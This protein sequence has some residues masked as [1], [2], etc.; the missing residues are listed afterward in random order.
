[1]GKNKINRSPVPRCHNHRVRP[2]YDGSPP[3]QKKTSALGGR[4]RPW[5]EAYFIGNDPLFSGTRS[6][7][8]T[9]PAK[10]IRFLDV[11][12]ARRANSLCI[13]QLISFPDT[14]GNPPPSA[15]NYEKI[16]PYTVH[17]VQCS[18]KEFNGAAK[19][20][21]TKVSQDTNKMGIFSAL[22]WTKTN[23]EST[24]CLGRMQMIHNLV[25]YLD[26]EKKFFSTFSA[27]LRAPTHS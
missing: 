7:Q 4:P 15:K 14:H 25:P 24:R 17:F 12:R 8:C 10:K 5:K 9:K 27:L 20:V 23:V 22:P 11:H 3:H 6:I 21:G 19:L 16:P 26:E 1:M 13:Q 18:S 2:C